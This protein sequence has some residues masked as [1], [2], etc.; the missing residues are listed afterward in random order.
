MNTTIP[1]ATASAFGTTA[2]ALFVPLGFGQDAID[3][4]VQSFLT[5]LSGKAKPDREP[6]RML[7]A[8]E[9]ATMIHR[10]T[11]TIREL[12]KRGKIRRIFCGADRERA[13]GYSQKS[14]EAFLGGGKE[15]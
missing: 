9:A 15:G 12:A 10:S 14:I 13:S 5:K 2:T 7:T 8:K 4:A 6:D 11:K 1:Q 3:E